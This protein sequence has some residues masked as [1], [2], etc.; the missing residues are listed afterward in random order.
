M[1]AFILLRGKD[2]SIPDDVSTAI[3]GLFFGLV[4]G[5]FYYHHY[6]KPWYWW[7]S[8]A[9]GLVF[10]YI[11]NL[12][13]RHLTSLDPTSVEAI[14]SSFIIPFVLT[15]LLNHALYLLKGR[16]RK[17]RRLRKSHSHFFDSV[18]SQEVFT[19]EARVGGSHGS[20]KQ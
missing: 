13:I 10:T 20:I 12:A 1:I 16:K 8:L 18:D 3:I 6:L 17:Q 7:V 19:K 14:L 2:F 4:C 15:L 11:V 5:L 9:G